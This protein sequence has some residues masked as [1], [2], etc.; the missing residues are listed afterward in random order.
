MKPKNCCY[1][2][3]FHC[4][5]P[6]CEWQDMERDI[7]NEKRRERYHADLGESRR[8]Q[9]EYRKSFDYNEKVREYRKSKSSYRNENG[10]NANQ[11]KVYEF[12][13]RYITKNLYS[14]T[15]AEIA[16]AV[17][18]AWSTAE[19]DVKRIQKQG[20]IQLGK[21]QR[22]IRLVGFEL[23]RK[24]RREDGETAAD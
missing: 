20:L 8:K 10:L 12:L 5:L 1:P 24:E 19:N 18:I 23:V 3:C 17:G 7:Q 21:G 11:Q 2:D 9:R 22:C 14:P 15:I 16:N 6:D 4:V 13:V